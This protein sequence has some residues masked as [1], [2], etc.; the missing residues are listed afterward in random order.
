MPREERLMEGM[1]GCGGVGGDMAKVD[2][3]ESTL[4]CTYINTSTLGSA[5]ILSSKSILEVY[6]NINP[7]NKFLFP[8]L[9]EGP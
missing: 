1:G 4:G 7:T 9:L 5:S 6:I 2:R 3:G 8:R